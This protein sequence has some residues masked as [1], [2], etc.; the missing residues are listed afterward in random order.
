MYTDMINR[1][2]ADLKR[3]TLR[4]AKHFSGRDLES[5]SELLHDDVFLLDPFVKIIAGKG[6]VLTF[7]KKIFDGA[8]HI[9]CDVRNLWMEGT[10]T[11]M[12]FQLTIDSAT[13]EGVDVIEWRDNRIVAIRAYVNAT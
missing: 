6:N 9:E 4:Y 11:I 10:T 7:L 5:I 13:L 8:D 1:H 2:T 3:E 12:E